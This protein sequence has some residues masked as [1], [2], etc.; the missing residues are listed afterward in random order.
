MKL[1]FDSSSYIKKFIEEPGSREIDDLLQKAS[2][3]ALSIICLPEIMS[4]LNRKVREGSL[5]ENGYQSVKQQI[6][7]DIHDIQMINLVPEVVENSI[8]LLENNKLRSL[9]ALH[10][11]C[12]LTW[13]TDLFISS[14]KRQ[15]IAAENSGLKVHLVV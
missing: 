2:T 11:T 5:T 13:N 12:A 14:D 9:E 1:F 8:K 15:I 6:I 7:E 4:A 10:I 3:L